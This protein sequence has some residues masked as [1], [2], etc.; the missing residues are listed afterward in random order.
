MQ[1]TPEQLQ[2]QG[3]EVKHSLEQLKK[4]TQSAD[5]AKKV[6]E[7]HSKLSSLQSE[8]EAALQAETDANKKQKIEEVKKLITETSA[9]AQTL[10]NSVEEKSTTETKSQTE[11]KTET[12]TKTEESL[13]DKSKNFVT[14]NV[15]A[16]F[17][18]ETWSK[19]TGLNIL[20]SAGLLSATAA[21]SAGIKG[22]WNWITGGDEQKEKKSD[23]DSSASK[24][25]DEKEKTGFWKTK[26]WRVLKWAGITWGAATAV[27]F[28][29][30]HFWRWGESATDASDSDAEKYSAYD[31][32]VK[33]P[34]NKE[35]AENYEKLGGNVDQLYGA[36]YHKELAAGYQD[37]LEMQKIAKEQSNG[38]QAYKGIVPFCLDN[39]FWSI[40]A[41]LGQHE[42]IRGALEGGLTGMVNYVK[43]QG[44]EFLKNFADSYLSKLPSWAK[45]MTGTN[46]LSERIDQWMVENKQAEQEMQYFFRQSIRIE[47]YLMEK[48]HQLLEKIA[49][50]K[51]QA[52]GRKK[53]DLLWNEEMREQYLYADPKY[54]AFMNAPIK[55]GAKILAEKGIFDANV[56]ENIQKAVVE[57]DRQRAEVL[58]AKDGEKDI[59]QIIAE[60]KANNAPLTEEEKQHLASACDGISKDINEEITEAA[61]E[62][63]FNIYG[64]LLN[65]DDAALRKYL[66]GSGLRLV[67]ES[68][69]KKIAEKKAELQAGTLPPDQIFA[70]SES[71]N[72]ML[73]LKKEV[74]LG[75]DTIQTSIDEHGNTLVRIEGFLRGS[76]NNLKKAW[77]KLRNGEWLEA[78]TYLG[79]AGLGA[80]CTLMLAGGVVRILGYKA[81]NTMMKTGFTVATFPLSLLYKGGKNLLSRSRAAHRLAD[82]VIYSSPNRVLSWKKFGGDEG[83]LALIDELKS[84]RLSLERAQTIVSSKTKGLFSAK[85]YKNW[86]AFFNLPE[87]KKGLNFI[88]VVFD[89]YVTSI[90]WNNIFLKEL[91]ADQDLYQSVIKNFDNGN[92]L[93][94][95]IVNDEWVDGIKRALQAIESRQTSSAASG[96][97]DAIKNSPSYKQLTNDIS[98]HIK[99]LQNELS[100]ATSAKKAQLTK[101]IQKLETFKQS[102]QTMGAK[103]LNTLQTL[104]SSMLTMVKKGGFFAHIDTAKQLLDLNNANLEKAIKELDQTKLAAQIDILK[105][106]GKLTNLSDEALSGF[107][108]VLDGLKAKQLVANSDEILAGFKTMV[109]YLWKLT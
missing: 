58:R 64:D 53:E 80:G 99:K 3:N 1:K 84:G 92:E 38:L 54:Q 79:S 28:V 29:G 60:K 15:K 108:E 69:Q 8:V 94:M 50:E 25:E 7:I 40:E 41:I 82:K 101:Q 44:A 100:N 14:D 90:Q 37:E 74:M 83:Y 27:Y 32:F 77:A 76:L 55:H 23:Q 49:A 33:L 57:I 86:D 20:R 52:T 71:L 39:K 61:E 75:A 96:V 88:E 36:L 42:S 102:L 22:L 4:E 107:S 43:M 47:T 51:A 12:T 104:Y 65:T 5:K 103:G 16:V 26:T 18:S 63:A 45:F 9:E 24:K 70:L 19:E 89:K 93:R 73:A 87:E 6:E 21:V 31:A 59:L 95:A 35:A 48:K 13:R 66:D 17:S 67:F 2:A 34:E 98:Q 68:Y 106:Q 11:T 30:K 10:A 78:T 85:S 46:S 81:G 56:G 72:A 97:L 109:K 105:K 62:S 91:K